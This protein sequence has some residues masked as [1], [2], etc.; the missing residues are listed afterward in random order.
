M[1]GL[2]Q[3]IANKAGGPLA[4]IGEISGQ[5]TRAIAIGAAAPA[6][7]AA[8]P[9]GAGGP[10]QAGAQ[11]AGGNHYSI[12]ITAQGNGAQD[13]AKQVRDAIEQIE[14]EKAARGR[15]TFRDDA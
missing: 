3:G 11:A 2:D 4:R 7:A 12:T 9:G 14:R 5:M 15:A 13:I 1:E 10:M 8:S 6:M